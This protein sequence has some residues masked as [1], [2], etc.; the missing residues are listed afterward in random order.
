MM[1][2]ASKMFGFLVAPS[3]LL[4]IALVV[5]LLLS[6]TGWAR[7]G[8]RI[9]ASAILFMA[10][11]GVGPGG[12]WLISPLENR[13]PAWDAARGAPDGIVVLGGS[14]SPD[15]SVARG[16]LALNESAERL[17]TIAGLARRFPDIPIVLVGGNRDPRPG[18]P[19]E[20][21]LAKQL[22]EDFGIAPARIRLEERSRSTAENAAFAK[23]LIDPAPGAR[24]LLVTSAHHMPRAVGLFRAAGFAVEAYPV[25][26]RLGGVKDLWGTSSSVGRGLA[27]TDTAFHEWIGLLVYRLSGR[28]SEFL[29]GP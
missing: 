18:E 24:W 19:S 20:S 13:F 3:N 12:N 29:P 1:F 4:L 22:L 28:T 23:A 8:R 17:T 25:D 2:A 26:W 27:R 6:L 14:I 15:H 21:R 7:G 9:L 5:A 11:F 10:L 16:A